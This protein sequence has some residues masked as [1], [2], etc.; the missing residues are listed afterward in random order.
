MG[1]DGAFP[2]ETGYLMIFCRLEFYT[3]KNHQN[4]ERRE[5]YQAK[6]ATPTFLKWSRSTI[7]FDQSDHSE[8][9]P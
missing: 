5:V 4:L 2:H 7:T 6:L 8:S 1:E 3:S 9:I